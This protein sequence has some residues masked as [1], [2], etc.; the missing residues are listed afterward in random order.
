MGRNV[1]PPPPQLP[2]RICGYCNRECRDGRA[3]VCSGCGAP[4]RA[5][6]SFIVVDEPDLAD[7]LSELRERVERRSKEMGMRLV[8]ILLPDQE[9]CK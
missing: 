8:P 5:M 4:L 9:N 3:E 2:A 1:P 7:K 6:Q